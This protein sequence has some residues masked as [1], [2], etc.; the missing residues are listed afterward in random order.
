MS[1]EE[2]IQYLMQ[3]NYLLRKKIR[4]KNSLLLK[5]RKQIQLLSLDINPKYWENTQITIFDL[6][7]TYNTH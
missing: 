7:D 1:T 6:Q 2:K 5:Y 3:E 4:E